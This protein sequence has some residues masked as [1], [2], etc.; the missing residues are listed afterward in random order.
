MCERLRPSELPVFCEDPNQ[1]DPIS[2]RVQLEREGLRERL[3]GDRRLLEEVKTSFIRDTPNRIALLQK[4]LVVR[5]ADGGQREAQGLEGIATTL[6]AT[7]LCR[8]AT[9]VEAACRRR[10]FDVAKTGLIEF[11]REYVRVKRTM[12]KAKAIDS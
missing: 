12:T 9:F 10:D 3:L 4:N 11:E 7:E 2:A 6:G 8:L 1:L 5:D